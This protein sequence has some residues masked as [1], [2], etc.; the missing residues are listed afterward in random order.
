MMRRRLGFTVDD[1]VPLLLE[2]GVLVPLL[3]VVVL[4]AVDSAATSVAFAMVV[5][6]VVIAFVFVFRLL[7]FCVCWL[8]SAAVSLLTCQPS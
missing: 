1:A 3:L 5:V 6:L 7:V 2:G 4:V 8:K